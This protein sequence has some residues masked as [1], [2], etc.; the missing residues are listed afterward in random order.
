MKCLDNDNIYVI[1]KGD[2]VRQFDCHVLS[3]DCK[4][5]GGFSTVFPISPKEYRANRALPDKVV[6]TDDGE[7]T[8]FLITD[9]LGAIHEIS[10][11]NLHYSAIETAKAKARENGLLV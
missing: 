5:G 11:D 9:D 1:E 6:I 2:Q 4:G 8:T 7:F 10:I 3:I